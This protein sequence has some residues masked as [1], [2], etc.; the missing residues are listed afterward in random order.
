M[1]NTKK[2]TVRTGES[3]NEGTITSGKLTVVMAE[4]KEIY[5]VTQSVKYELSLKF[6]NK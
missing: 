5:E 6:K 4:N 1:K 3:L 2:S